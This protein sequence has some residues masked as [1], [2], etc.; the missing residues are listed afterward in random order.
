MLVVTV[1]EAATLGTPLLF[2]SHRGSRLALGFI[3]ILRLPWSRNKLFI[4]YMEPFWLLII[5][6]VVVGNRRSRSRRRRGKR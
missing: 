1:L 5:A 6:V 4:W 2:S 3:K